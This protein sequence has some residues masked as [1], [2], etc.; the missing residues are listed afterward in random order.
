MVPRGGRAPRLTA[1]GSSR[2]NVQHR[3]RKRWWHPPGGAC[4]VQEA[5]GIP[6]V[7]VHVFGTP[8]D[9]PAYV[10]DRG[11]L[12][13]ARR[14]RSRPAAG[15]SS[16]HVGRRLLGDATSCCTV[17][18]RR[19]APAERRSVAGPRRTTCARHGIPDSR[20]RGAHGRAIA[21]ERLPPAPD[22]LC[23]E[24]FFLPT[25][26]PA[27]SRDRVRR[28]AR[29]VRGRA[30]GVRANEPAAAISSRVV[31]LPHWAAHWVRTLL[32]VSA[33]RSAS[34]PSWRS[35]TSTGR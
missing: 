4:A 8:E 20:P 35:P 13:R 18:P 34:P 27:L 5:S 10:P 30:T 31:S 14:G 1:F 22:G 19:R 7:A 29:L 26:W 32:T 2:E 9:L 21:A 23:A 12:V 6:G 17:E 24:L 16:L 33:S 3:R 11:V 28:R 15:R 25:L